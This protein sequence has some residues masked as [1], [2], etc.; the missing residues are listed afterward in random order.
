VTNLNE[1]VYYMGYKIQLGDVTYDKSGSTNGTEQIA[2]EVENLGSEQATFYGQGISIDDGSTQLGSAS[3]SDAPTILAKSKGKATLKFDLPDNY[4]PSKTYLVMGDG[5]EQQVRLLL[6]GTTDDKTKLDTPIEQNVPTAPVTIGV[7]TYTPASSEVR[8]DNIEDHTQAKK[9]KVLW[10][11]DGTLK[12]GSADKT[13]YPSEGNVSLSLPDGTKQN[14]DLF[15]LQTAGSLD[16]TKTDN[17]TLLFTI[18]EPFAGKYGVDFK[19]NWSA[20]D[21]ESD[22]HIDVTLTDQASGTTTGSTP[23]STPGTTTG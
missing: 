2:L 11:T 8:Y 10:Y 9:G 3:V 20:D 5:T 15:K 22:A 7:A 6:D 16:P 13:L 18:P 12:N 19:P 21:S 17:I 4:D 1:T 14:A 23:G